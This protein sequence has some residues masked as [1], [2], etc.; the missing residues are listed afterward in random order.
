M[1]AVDF[2]EVPLEIACSFLVGSTSQDVRVEGFPQ[3]FFLFWEDLLHVL[4]VLRLL[5]ELELILSSELAAYVSYNRF[6]GVA[7]SG[8]HGARVICLG[9]IEDYLQVPLLLLLIDFL[10]YL[11]LLLL[12]LLPRR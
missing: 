4:G 1:D 10:P 11:F 3:E 12:L 8:D 6:F 2:W 7:K 9:V 5:D